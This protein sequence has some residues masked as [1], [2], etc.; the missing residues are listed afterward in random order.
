MSRI[1]LTKLKF[2]QLR[3]L[4]AVADTGNFSQAAAKLA[5][6]QSTISHAIA[7]LEDELGAIL[8]K[9]GRQGAFLTSI[10]AD[11]A[12][13]ARSVL[14]LLV[15]IGRKAE[16]ARSLE[17]GELTIACF[18]SIGTHIL[19]G[20]IAQFHRRFPGIRVTINEYQLFRAVEDDIRQGGADLGFTYLPAGPEFETRE[21]FRDDYI[22]L[23]PPDPPPPETLTWEHLKRYPLILSP[24]EYGCHQIITNYLAHHNQQIDPAYEVKE[25]S[26]ILGMV[27]RGLGATVMARLAAQPIP[28]GI[29]T[30]SL[31]SLLERVIGA[32][33]L[34][35]VLHPPAVFAFVDTLQQMAQRE[36]NGAVADE[37]M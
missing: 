21:L 24:E 16:S 11:I 13:D 10:G 14:D 12:A 3:A 28:P 37:S 8:V 25:D 33:F 2:S 19:P 30:R 32:A 23:L 6:S 9:R 27:Q 31:P 20:A 5:L 18:R 36:R 34:A 15:E 17:T 7:T 1:D 4:V 29:V 26:T 35:D 22:A